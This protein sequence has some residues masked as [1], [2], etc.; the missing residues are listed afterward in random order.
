MYKSGGENGKFTHRSKK[1]MMV[2]KNHRSW[3]EEL[4]VEFCQYTAPRAQYINCTHNGRF[5]VL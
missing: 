4:G 2:G 3:E 5:R 1:N